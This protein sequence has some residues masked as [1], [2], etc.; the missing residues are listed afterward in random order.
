MECNVKEGCGA[1]RHVQEH[2]STYKEIHQAPKASKKKK[3]KR[4]ARQ[5]YL[6]TAEDERIGLE[7]FLYI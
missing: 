2:T 4:K 3:K 5:C 1:L 6:S 7:V